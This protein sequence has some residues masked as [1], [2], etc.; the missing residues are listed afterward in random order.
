MGSHLRPSPGLGG[1][2][3][4]SPAPRDRMGSIDAYSPF[5]RTTPTKTSGALNFHDPTGAHIGKPG[6]S[7]QGPDHL[8]SRYPSL[9]PAQ[10]TGAPA[11]RKLQPT[12]RDNQALEESRF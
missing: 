5:Q 1:L 12:S 9:E 8:P 2:P 7:L 10:Q 4:C 6:P 3:G 11:M